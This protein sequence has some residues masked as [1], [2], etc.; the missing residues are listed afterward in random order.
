[1][2]NSISIF[3]ARTIFVYGEVTPCAGIRYYTYL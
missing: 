3:V 1:M 2:K